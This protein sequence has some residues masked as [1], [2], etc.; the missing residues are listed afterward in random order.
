[1]IL[2]VIILIL[3]FTLTF[4]VRKIAI[5]RKIIDIPIERSSHTVPT[6]RGGGIAIVIAWYLGLCYEFFFNELDLNFFLALLSGL[7]L[8]I[9][10]L[11]DDIITL[12]PKIRIIAQLLSTGLAFYFLG[13]LSIVDLGFYKIE[14]VYIL[15]P[16]AFIGTIWLI[17]LFNFLDGIDGYL[18]AETIFIFI[19]IFAI[20][21][22]NIALIFAFATLGFLFWNW[23][24]AKIFMGDVGSTLIGF[25]IAIFLI[26]YQNLEDISIFTLLILSSIFW[27]DATW[28]LFRRFRNK[29]KL[30]EAH[31]KHAYQRLVQ[32]GFSHQKTVLISM[33]LN[34]LNLAL[35]YLAHIYDK[36]L[37]IFF[38]CSI[39]LSYIYMKFADKRKPF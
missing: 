9:V 20:F 5:S 37:L 15:T 1:M 33:S 14:S 11:L 12:S 4:L 31:K 25:N 21:N 36:Y 16:I 13:G 27:F 32:S 30:T 22:G 8:V 2:F 17:N 34:I 18:G 3:S 39:V 6:P 29:E 10:G 38:F 23:Q 19:T 24:P 28:T 26:Y 7:I 35:F